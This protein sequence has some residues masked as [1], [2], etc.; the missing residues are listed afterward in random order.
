MWGAQ[1][2]RTCDLHVRMLVAGES[3]RVGVVWVV[4]TAG[5]CAYGDYHTQ[6]GHPLLCVWACDPGWLSS[7]PALSGSAIR[8]TA[9]SP[10]LRHEREIDRTQAGVA[11]LGPK[12]LDLDQKSWT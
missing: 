3:E 11:G 2:E 7:N 6:V 4:L 9:R 8:L 5:R 10:V 12:V 1:I